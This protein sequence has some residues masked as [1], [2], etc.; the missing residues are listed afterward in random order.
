MNIKYEVEKVCNPGVE[1]ETVR[2][3]GDGILENV[4]I[5]NAINGGFPK[6]DVR[7]KWPLLSAG[8]HHELMG[9]R[10]YCS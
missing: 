4:S 5:I 6:G 3:G 9:L 7:C 2:A 10:T 8:R 1:I